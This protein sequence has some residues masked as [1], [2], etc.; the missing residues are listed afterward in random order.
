ML[1]LLLLPSLLWSMEGA[2]GHPDSW[3]LTVKS[4]VCVERGLCVYVPCSFSSSKEKWIDSDIAYG[5]WF[6]KKSSTEKILVAT[7][8][9]RR[10]VQD[11]TQAVFQLLGDPRKG[12]CSLS[13]TGAKMGKERTYFFRLERGET[14]YSYERFT[15][16]VQVTDLIHMLNIHIPETLKLGQTYNLTCAVPWP[17]EGGTPPSL[18]WKRVSIL[19]GRPSSLLS[20]VLTLT[21][22]LQDQGTELICQVTFPGTGVTKEKAVRLNVSYSPRNVTVLV[23]RGNGTESNT[24]ENGSTLQVHEGQYLRLVCVASSNPPCRL[25]WVWSGL[26][27]CPS[28]PSEAGVLVIPRVHAHNE[29]EFACQAQ[30]HLGTEHVFLSLALHQGALSINRVALGAIGGAS[31]TAMI[32]FSFF[33]IFLIVRSLRKRA[34]RRAVGTEDT[35]PEY[36]EAV[37]GSVSQV[38]DVNGFTA[39]RPPLCTPLQAPRCKPREEEDLYY[40]TICFSGKD[41]EHVQGQEA[42]SSVYAEVKSRKREKT[43]TRPWL[44]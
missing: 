27:L 20:S 31:V 3:S 41:L 28:Q 42:S 10:P 19:P 22:Q 33:F 15:L 11:K 40:A 4:R 23:F 36:A 18:S 6:W 5:F 25:S 7:N 16:S 13:I 29:G 17:C 34:A 1:L 44:E 43:E 21:P 26:T 14:N 8:H 2:E 12:N 37:P 38:S 32:S 9:P 35:G 24:I 30:N 39:I